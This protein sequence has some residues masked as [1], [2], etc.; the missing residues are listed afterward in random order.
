M[1]CNLCKM[2]PQH[3][4]SDK[5]HERLQQVGLTER[6]SRAG[7]TKAAWITYYVCEICGTKWQH[8]DDPANTM[9]GW[10]VQKQL[11]FPERCDSPPSKHVAAR[12]S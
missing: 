4:R 12:H 2:L 6:V 7:K 5:R 10:S 9:A 11:A 3:V 8:V 1:P